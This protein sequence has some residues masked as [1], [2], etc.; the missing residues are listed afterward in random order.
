MSIHITAYQ[1]RATTETITLRDADGVAIT[2]LSADR[3]RIKVGRA[4]KTPILDI[5]GGTPMS[6]G[7]TINNANPATL[8]LYAADLGNQAIKPG[9]YE[10]EA[11]V[12]D[13]ADSN[14]LKHAESGVF[15]LIGTQLG[16]VGLT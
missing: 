1:S 5:L 2:L 8:K 16:N 11:M 6:G 13:T 9:V 14:R 4:G 3:I 15:T 12:I 7:T 10:I